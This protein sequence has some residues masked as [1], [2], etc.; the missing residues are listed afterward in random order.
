MTAWKPLR[1]DHICHP[2]APIPGYIS[3]DSLH[4]SCKGLIPLHPL[5]TH[6]DLETGVRQGQALRVKTQI[7]DLGPSELSLARETVI[8]DVG[9]HDPV[10][11][12][13]RRVS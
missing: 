13:Q 8:T 7:M 1:S 3:F 12:M 5:F 10:L 11:R 9:Q 6:P 4:P 2:Q